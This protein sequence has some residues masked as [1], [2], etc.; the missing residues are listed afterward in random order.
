MASVATPS[1]DR[2][3]GPNLPGRG[4]AERSIR[5]RINRKSQPRGALRAEALGKTARHEEIKKLLG[6]DL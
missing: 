4:V 1:L 5:L 6:H 2:C 3:K